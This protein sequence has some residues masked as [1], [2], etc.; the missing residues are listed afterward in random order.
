MLWYH[1]DCFFQ[2]FQDQVSSISQFDGFFDLP[3]DKQG[4][5]ARRI[6]GKG[7]E[8]SLPDDDSPE[9]EQNLLKQQNDDL[10]EL[11]KLLKDH[12]KRTDLIHL[13]KI[14]GQY[15]PTGRP[16]KLRHVADV[17][18]F[19]ALLPCDQCVEGP[20]GRFMFSNGLYKCMGFRFGKCDNTAKTPPRKTAIIPDSLHASIAAFCGKYDARVLP[21]LDEDVDMVMATSKL[22]LND[23]EENSIREVFEKHVLKCM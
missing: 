19:G 23:S 11:Q 20:L 9:G 21:V 3:M 1:V 6:A 15:V 7:Q 16:E 17:I 18:L 13:L 5:L 2:E 4:D 22:S 8:I 12:T 10:F 14:N